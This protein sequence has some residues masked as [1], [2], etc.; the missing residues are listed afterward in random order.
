MS[1]LF[2]ETEI[3]N[4]QDLTGKKFNLLTVTGFSHRKRKPSGTT[5]F[6]KCVC[7]CPDQKT[8]VVQAHKL[9]TGHT[10]SCGCHQ[11][12][13]AKEAKTVHGLCRTKLIEREHPVYTSYRGMMDRCYNP[14]H[15]A[16]KYYGGNNP[17]VSVCDRWRNKPKAFANDMMPS[18]KPRLTIDRRNPF[19]NYTPSNCRWETRSVQAKNTRR[20]YLILLAQ[21]KIV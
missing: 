20:N 9:K 17:P 1:A 15:S 3:G 19:K 2:S 4:A 18:W 21:K 10:Q 16:W 11:R 13:R 8:V 12:M 5:I 7:C 6:W 14:N